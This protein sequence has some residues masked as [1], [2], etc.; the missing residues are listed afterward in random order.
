MSHFNNQHK[1]LLIA[2]ITGKIME[3]LMGL[4]RKN[5]QLLRI[6][7]EKTS[8]KLI[9]EYGAAVKSQRRKIRQQQFNIEEKEPAVIPFLPGEE[10]QLAA[11]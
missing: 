4:N 2:E 5:E 3:Y 11:S 7:A 9:R 8:A 6:L 1:N 10:Q